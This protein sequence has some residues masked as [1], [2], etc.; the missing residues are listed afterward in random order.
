MPWTRNGA[1]RLEN[2]FF[3]EPGPPNARSATQVTLSNRIACGQLDGQAAAA[4][5]LVTELSGTGMPI[6][7]AV[8]R[9]EG[10]AS[11]NVATLNL[12]NRIKINSLSIRDGAVV[13]DMMV[14]T[15]AN[16]PCCPSLRVRRRYTLTGDR[17]WESSEESLGEVIL[18]ANL[19]PDT[20]GNLAYQLGW[21]PGTT[22]TLADGE[23]RHRDGGREDFAVTLGAFFPRG[24]LNGAPAAAVILV[25]EAD[26]GRK[27]YDLAAVVDREG[28]PVNAATTPLGEGLQIADLQIA[29]NRIDVSMAV[30]ENGDRPGSPAGRAVQQYHLQDGRLVRN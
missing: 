18:F 14:H 17:L 9:S 1:A 3:T 19:Y 25:T 11:V 27:L 15:P 13:A 20:L 24:D 26:D 7:L 16:H 6:D 29:E 4:A 2:G 10:G 23:Y 5:L 28:Q 8:V 21:S 12:G 30:P 22:V